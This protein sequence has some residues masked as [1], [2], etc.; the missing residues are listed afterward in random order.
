MILGRVFLVN[1][2]ETLSVVSVCIIAR[3]FPTAF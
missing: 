2:V 3:A 1:E